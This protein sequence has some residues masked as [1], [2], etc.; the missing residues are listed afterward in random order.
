MIGKPSKTI[1]PDDIIDVHVHIGGPAGEND[2]MYY[3]SKKFR[4]STAYEG[5]KLVTKLAGSQITGPKYLSV[6]LSEVQQAKHI[7]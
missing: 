7:D 4:K 5:M 2:E 6:L 1:K 3:F